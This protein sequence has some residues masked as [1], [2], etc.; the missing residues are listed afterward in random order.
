MTVLP[1]MIS[2]D[3]RA[4]PGSA[5]VPDTVGEFSGLCK[6]GLAGLPECGRKSAV[7]AMGLHPT[8]TFGAGPLSITDPWA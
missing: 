8:R 3:A 5:G 1:M 4:F 6:R 2:R 7:G